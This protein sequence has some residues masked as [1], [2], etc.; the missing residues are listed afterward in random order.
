MVLI[1]LGPFALSRLLL[2]LVFSFSHGLY[3]LAQTPM[4][5]GPI[6]SLSS[7]PLR[8]GSLTFMS[9]VAYVQHNMLTSG[10][11]DYELHH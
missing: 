2:P 9:L 3:T 11:C 1:F 7:L 4:S 5:L 10:L 8:M 6:Q